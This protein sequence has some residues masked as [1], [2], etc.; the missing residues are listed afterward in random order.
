MFVHVSNYQH[1]LVEGRQIL[2]VLISNEVIDSKDEGQHQ[3]THK[4]DSNRLIPKFSRAKEG[5]F[6]YLF[7]LAMEALSQILLRGKLPYLGLSLDHSFKPSTTQ[8]LERF[9]KEPHFVEGN[10][11]LKVNRVTLIGRTLSSL[12]IYFMFIIPKRQKC[13]DY[14]CIEAI[15]GKWLVEPLFSSQFHDWELEVLTNF[16]Q[17][18]QTCSVQREED[19][20]SE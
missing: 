1:T 3:C 14:G 9:S 15:W 16:F 13:M 19:D 2:D 11:N 6:P 12:P 8:D 7:I 18:L 20:G 5:P 17:K 4:W 10:I